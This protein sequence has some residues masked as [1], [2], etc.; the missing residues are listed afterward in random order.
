LFTALQEQLGLK[1]EAACA[2]V[3]VV[4]IERL[5]PPLPTEMKRAG[6]DPPALDGRAA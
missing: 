5:E 1:L 3:E 6:G 4:V 2:P